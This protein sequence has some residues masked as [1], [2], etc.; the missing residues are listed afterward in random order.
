MSENK[1]FNRFV[2]WVG[3]VGSLASIVG[4]G[5]AYWDTRLPKRELSIIVV[6]KNFLLSR[7]LEREFKLSYRGQPVDNV[8]TFLVEIRN[9]GRH[10][11]RRD[12]F[13]SP[14]EFWAQGVNQVVSS[15]EVKSIP[16]DISLSTEF[17]QN[18]VF[19]DP[20]LLNPQD[21]VQFSI[22]ALCDHLCNKKSSVDLNLES[23]RIA[24]ISNIDFDNKSIQED[25]RAWLILL[26]IGIGSLMLY[27]FLS[28]SHIYMFLPAILQRLPESSAIRNLIIWSM[29]DN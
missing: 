10:P 8:A 15:E 11:I 16:N 20:L 29:R 23:A 13:E 28:S 27:S 24:G 2:V 1:P 25:N 17:K 22:T 26:A 3:I 4:L 7:P 6:S 21:M 19:V 5:W 12:D 14:L 18:K 9:T